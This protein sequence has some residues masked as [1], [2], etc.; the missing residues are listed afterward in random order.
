MEEQNLNEGMVSVQ[1]QT[2]NGQWNTVYNTQ[3]MP[4][5]VLKS[6]EQAKKIFPKARIRAIDTRTGILVDMM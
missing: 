2:R 5:Y 3:N 1:Y 4:L 6:M